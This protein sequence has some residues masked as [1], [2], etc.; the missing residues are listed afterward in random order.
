M[1]DSFWS[2]ITDKVREVFA[3]KAPAPLPAA[4]LSYAYTP[5]HQGLPPVA[6]PQSTAPIAYSAAPEMPANS[7]TKQFRSPTDAPSM[8]V[9][10]GGLAGLMAARELLQ[11]GYKVQMYEAGGR[12]GG[13]IQS[14]ALGGSGCTVNA[15]AEIVDASNKV[16]RKLC[17]E[18]GVE[19]IERATL[20]PGRDDAYSVGGKRY[21]DDD[22]VNAETGQGAYAALR[23]Q[24]ASDQAAMRDAGGQWT[25][26]GRMLDKMSADEYLRRHAHLAPEWVMKVIRAAFTSEVGRDLHEQ[27][28]LN[29]I[30]FACCRTLGTGPDQSFRLYDSDET[31]V[32]KGGTEKII[33]ACAP[34]FSAWPMR[35]PRRASA[36]SST[37]T[38]IPN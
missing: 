35:A 19:L 20:Q 31:Y 10:G 14:A 36:R 17:D 5:A 24:I 3:D 6:I 12:V 1:A 22:M 2:G 15:G 23:A 30:D 32:V 13:R 9:V 4:P 7:F 21:S 38:P 27:S 18:L 8:A 33:E 28:A 16:M 26:H 11:Q 29:V 25:E 34:I 37:C